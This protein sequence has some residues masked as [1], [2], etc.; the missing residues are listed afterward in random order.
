[1]IVVHQS[2]N[3][4]VVRTLLDKG[5]AQGAEL[6]A[7]TKSGDTPLHLASW[8]GNGTIVQMLLDKGTDVNVGKVKRRSTPLHC[9]ASGGN[10]TVVLMLMDNAADV[11]PKTKKGD[12][13]LHAAAEGGHRGG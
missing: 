10:D 7:T 13:P 9:A 2:E 8:D 12:T 6:H 11:H 5:G 3:D 1:M 4:E